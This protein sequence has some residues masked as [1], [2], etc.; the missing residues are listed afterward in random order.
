MSFLKVGVSTVKDSRLYVMEITIPTGDIYYKFGKSSGLSSK[1]RM[2][3][4]CGSVFDKY[5]QT[6]AIK[7]IRDRKVGADVV[8][9][10]ENT[11]HKFFSFYQFSDRLHTPF[12][13]SSECFK[14]DKD[15]AIQAYDAVMEGLVPDFVYH[16]EEDQIPF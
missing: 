9:R 3:Q 11:L 5:R 8:F 12:S 6:P 13:G 10:Y 7:I 2:L 16:K 4:I 14:I 15:V 1:E